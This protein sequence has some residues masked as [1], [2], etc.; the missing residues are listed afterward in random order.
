MEQIVR[1]KV[2]AQKHSKVHALVHAL[3]HTLGWEG[4]PAALL[5]AL[6]LT[7]QQPIPMHWQ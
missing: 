3:E 2:V 5:N 1:E 4:M 7:P 6:V